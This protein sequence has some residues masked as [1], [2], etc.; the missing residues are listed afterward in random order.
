L[1]PSPS[2]RPRLEPGHAGQPVAE[3]VE[4]HDLGLEVAELQRHRVE[5]RLGLLL[6]ALRLLALV[7]ED[8]RLQPRVLDRR[9]PLERQVVEREREHHEQGEDD[10][11]DDDAVAPAE[12]ERPRPGARTADQYDV[13]V[14][15]LP[16]P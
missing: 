14:D 7:G 3:A 6:R 2:S 9:G 13:H 15:S 16:I 10:E 5:V 12:R 1:R 4:A 8:D 11:R